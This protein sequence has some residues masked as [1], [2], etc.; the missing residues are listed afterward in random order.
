[1]ASTGSRPLSCLGEW[2]IPAPTQCCIHMRR[3]P[4]YA[5]C[6]AAIAVTP[7]SL[8]KLLP[9]L[10]RSNNPDGARLLLRGLYRAIQG[11]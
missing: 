4:T 7:A 6:T 11:M 10:Y 1:M 5:Q 2:L 9:F 8:S 3:S